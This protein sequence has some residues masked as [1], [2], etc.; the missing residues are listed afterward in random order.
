MVYKK[1]T[2][3]IQLKCLQSDRKKHHI[4]HQ[5]GDRLMQE[6]TLQHKQMERMYKDN[7]RIKLREN[8][9]VF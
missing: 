1:S 4:L 6:Q 8:H 3:C 7:A 9:R 2:N 5:K